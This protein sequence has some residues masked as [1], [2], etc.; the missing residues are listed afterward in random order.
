MDL[1]WVEKQ[2]RGG[3]IVTASVVIGVVAG[4][5]SS[6]AVAQDE[7][8]II[9]D[10]HVHLVDFLQNGDYLK[11]GDIVPKFPGAV[12]A[13]GERGRRIEALLWA[14]DRA[15]VSQALVSG[16]PFIK[17]WSEDEPLRPSYYLDAT[18]RVVRARDTDY[19]LALAV[20][21]FARQGGEAAVAQLRRL[22]PCVSG[23]DGTDMGAVDMIVKR[24]QEFPGVFRCIGEVMSRHDDL[25]NLTTGERPRANHP[26]LLR[27]FDF[28]GEQ[29]IPV[30]VHH[31]IAPVSPDG[32]PRAPIYLAEL[33][34]AFAAA[35]QTT[36][37]WCHA[38]VSRRIRIVDLPGHLDGVLAAHGDHVFI[39]LSWVVVP[40]YVLKDLEGWIALIRRYPDNFLL[41][42]DAVG[43]FGDYTE[44]I[45]VY[46]PL[47]EALT[48]PELIEKL[49][50]GNFLKIMREEGIVLDPAYRYPEDRYTRAPIRVR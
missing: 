49:A 10:A 50:R 38:G 5:L 26:A 19:H 11:D 3:F 41:G 31:N 28:A 15:N 12:L 23:F 18:S 40:E 4:F 24:L 21:D 48:D 20:E 1:G 43:R 32:A 47:F 29:G 35:P 2:C 37:I 30:S 39:D 34:E 45:R 9:A 8:I 25:T 42:S 27:I 22:H 14:M 44:Q 33:L 6:E 13:A 36:F 46:A 7:D 17:K 16:M